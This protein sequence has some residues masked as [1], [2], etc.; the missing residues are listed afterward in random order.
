MITGSW[1]T[2]LFKGALGKNV[3]FFLLPPAHGKPL[4]TLGGEGLPWSISSKSKNP[5][6]AATYLNYITN[7][8]SQ[9]VAAN[10]GQLTATKYKV[11]V[12]GGLDSAV[13]AQWVKANKLDA[14][15]P[16]LDWATPTMYDTSTA[17]IQEL[18]AG[19]KSPSQFVDTIQNDYKKFHG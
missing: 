17:A 18:L 6:A 4:A 19:K 14:I 11:K 12:P 16:Y 3:G 2:S 10:N 5:D 1:Q 8:Q 13:Y 9:Q 15:V 7:A